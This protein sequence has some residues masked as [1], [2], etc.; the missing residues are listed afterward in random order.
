MGNVDNPV[1]EP[2][3]EFWKIIGCSGGEY[4]VETVLLNGEG[5]VFMLCSYSQQC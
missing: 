2:E 5:L 1:V 3:L 4:K